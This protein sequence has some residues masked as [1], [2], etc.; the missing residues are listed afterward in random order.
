MTTI[1]FNNKRFILIDNSENGKVNSDTI[2]EYKQ[3]G[4]LVTADYYGGSV[5][6]GK[7]IAHIQNDKLE[8]LYQCL[9]I[10]NQLKAGKSIAEIFLTDNQKIKLKLDWE[11]ITGDKTSGK[12]EFIEI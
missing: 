12:S 6:Y 1:N 9:T 8:M 2:F 3:D 7:I 4:N 10:D 5:K 11:W